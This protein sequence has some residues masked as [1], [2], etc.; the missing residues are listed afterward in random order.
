MAYV[1]V[2]VKHNEAC[3]KVLLS[4]TLMGVKWRRRR[5]QWQSL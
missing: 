5:R 2:N 1:Y 4:Q 3:M